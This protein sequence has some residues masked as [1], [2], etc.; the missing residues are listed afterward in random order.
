MRGAIESNELT[1][2]ATAQW[3]RLLFSR[4][5]PKAAAPAVLTG[6]ESLEQQATTIVTAADALSVTVN[7]T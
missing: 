6:I 1:S 3:Q 4:T 2:T 7:V 5:T